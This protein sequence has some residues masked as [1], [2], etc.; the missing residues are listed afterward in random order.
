MILVDTSVWVS[1][2]QNKNDVLA[3]RLDHT[4]MLMH[5]FVLGELALGGLAR[6]PVVFGSLRNLPTATLAT[7]ATDAEMQ[8]CR[9]AGLHRATRAV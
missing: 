8:R 2:L 6:R 3:Q 5:P 9:D 4:G 1:H 7:S